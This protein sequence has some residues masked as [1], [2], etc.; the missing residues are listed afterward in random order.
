M[1]GA[2]VFLF[3]RRGLSDVFD[4]GQRTLR[5]FG[6]AASEAEHDKT[7]HSVFARLDRATQY[8][9]VSVMDREAAAYWIPAFQAV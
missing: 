2:S 6:V 9:R 5:A 3:E 7:A 8:S 4:K 1:G